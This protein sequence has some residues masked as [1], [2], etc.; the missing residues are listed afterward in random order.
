MILYECAISHALKAINIHLCN[1]FP[2]Q[3]RSGT[4]TNSIVVFMI[5]SAKKPVELIIIHVSCCHLPH[6]QMACIAVSKP[7]II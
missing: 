4:L 7:Y 5:T 6:T 2:Q 1:V 3:Q